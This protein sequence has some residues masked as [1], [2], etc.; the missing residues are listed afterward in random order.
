LKKKYKKK[1]SLLRF[2]FRIRRMRRSRRFRRSRRMRRMKSLKRFKRSK[3]FKHL[4]YLKRTNR[5][6]RLRT[7]KRFKR[8]NRF[9][10]RRSRKSSN[11]VIQDSIKSATIS[12]PKL[13]KRLSFSPDSTKKHSKTLFLKISSML[14]LISTRLPFITS[15]TTIKLPYNLSRTFSTLKLNNTRSRVSTRNKDSRLTYAVYSFTRY[16]IPRF[17]KKIYKFT[18]FSTPRRIQLIVSQVYTNIRVNITGAKKTSVLGR[19]LN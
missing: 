17:I 8:L 16:Y 9:K 10:R 3:R 11:K 12:K 5:L 14:T 2:S 1:V 4:K 13:L 18:N 7:L 15:L 19:F 6:K